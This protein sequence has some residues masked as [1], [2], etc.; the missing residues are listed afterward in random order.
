VSA[1]P[2]ARPTPRSSFVTVTAWLGIGTSACAAPIALV[3]TLM[4]GTLSQEIR[5]A[6]DSEA[7]AQLPASMRYLLEHTKLVSQVFLLFSAL[8]LV[9]SVGLLRRRNWGRL[10][11]MALLAVLIVQQL[12]L[13]AL[14]LSMGGALGGPGETPRELGAALL[15][16][17]VAGGVLT[18][19]QVGVC[20]WMIWKLETPAIRAEFGA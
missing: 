20:A 14:Q 2:P 17:Q 5:T 6:L 4:V 10:A 19:L 12:A 11:V 15:L 7:L 3:Q 9:A 18:V 16:L 8:T 13:F 1:K